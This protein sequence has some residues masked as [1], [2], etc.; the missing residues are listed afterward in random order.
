MTS[1]ESDFIPV[2]FL[3]IFCLFFIIRDITGSPLWGIQITLL[4]SLL[5]LLLHEFFRW[6]R[7]RAE[8]GFILIIKEVAERMEKGEAFE[9]AIHEFMKDG[10]DRFKGRDFV[11][12]IDEAGEKYSSTFQGA[13]FQLISRMLERGAEEGAPLLRFAIEEERLREV[14]DRIRRAIE[15]RILI[16]RFLGL[17]LVPLLF[18]LLPLIAGYPLHHIYF[19]FW[20]FVA[21]TLSL[22]D[23]LV[24]F[25][26]ESS[27]SKL[28]FF[29]SL[30]WFSLK[31]LPH[32]FGG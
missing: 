14:A 8:K 23:G 6:R 1:P 31:T 17:F 32:I 3:S 4:L 7:D 29:L 12:E 27:I 15:T 28:P 20:L 11:K 25:D 24:H 13:V 21:F 30:S 10:F 26:W 22:T 18:V 2:S 16:V 9:S 5:P 19:Y